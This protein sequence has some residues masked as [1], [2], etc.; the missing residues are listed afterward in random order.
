MQRVAIYHCF[1]LVD[2]LRVM[3]QSWKINFLLSFVLGYPSD[4]PKCK[5]FQVFRFAYFQYYILQWIGEKS[6]AFR[7]Y[8]DDTFQQVF[9]YFIAIEALQNVN[10]MYLRLYNLV[11][12]INHMP[13]FYRL[14]VHFNQKLHVKTNKGK[15]SR[16]MDLFVLEKG[17]FKREY[18]ETLEGAVFVSQISGSGTIRNYLVVLDTLIT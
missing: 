7:I 15:Y 5:T 16:G 2:Y 14:L 3:I 10:E 8:F 17:S 4:C 18:R 12:K 9:L 11:R 13:I 1:Q 6:T